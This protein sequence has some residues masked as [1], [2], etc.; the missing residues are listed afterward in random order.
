[1]ARPRQYTTNA[2]RQ[3]AYRLRRAQRR[4]APQAYTQI[5]DCTLYCGDA[6]TLIDTISADALVA[7]PPY[8]VDLGY[9]NNQAHD[10]SHLHKGR[11][12]AYRDTY[13]AFSTA[14][15]A[16]LNRAIDGTRCGAVF[17][18]PHIHE[19]RKPVAIGGI[20]HPSAVGRT[21][22]GS[23][24]FLPILFYGLPP[25]PGQHR[26][27][28]MQSMA[29]AETNA[30]PCPKPLSWMRWL[31]QLATTPG[32]TVLD[33]FMGSGTTGVAC[34][35]MGRKFIGIEQDPA[36]FELACQRIRASATQGQ[37]FIPATKAHQ[38]T[39]F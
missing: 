25:A 10:R 18:G 3:A 29:Q 7:D 1:M 8:G 20:W 39:L 9:A 14:V 34:V 12:G 22:W 24:N 17:T 37:L 11:Y 13:E 35:E 2:E 27:L 36:Y 15:V 23:K 5:G 31:V 4:Q 21:P 32:E 26:P 19:Q 6:T 28:V 33:P 38:E 30:H 16:I